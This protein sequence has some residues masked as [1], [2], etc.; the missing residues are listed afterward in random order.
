[1]C[2]G[3]VGAA[4]LGDH[5]PVQIPVLPAGPD[6]GGHLGATQDVMA[7]KV[8]VNSSPPSTGGGKRGGPHLVPLLGASFP[9]PQNC[10]L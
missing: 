9:D 7:G 6:L 1:M 3:T 4:S 2:A 10:V 5:T 8:L